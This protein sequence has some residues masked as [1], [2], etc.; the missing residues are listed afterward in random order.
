MRIAQLYV[1]LRRCAAYGVSIAMA[2]CL[3][4][5]EGAS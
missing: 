4:S 5:Q 2:A 1:A 3:Q